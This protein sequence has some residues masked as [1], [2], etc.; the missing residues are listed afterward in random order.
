MAK[1]YTTRDKLI[2]ILRLQIKNEAAVIMSRSRSVESL[3]A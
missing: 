1:C 3:N 2:L